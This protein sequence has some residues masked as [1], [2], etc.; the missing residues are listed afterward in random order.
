MQISQVICDTGIVNALIGKQFIYDQ[1]M[2]EVTTSFEFTSN[3]SGQS[4]V[5]MI[6]SQPK[7][8]IGIITSSK[9]YVN[10]L[11]FSFLKEFFSIP[12]N[13][14]TRVGRATDEIITV[15]P[16]L[17]G[18]RTSKLNIYQNILPSDKIIMQGI[19]WLHQLVLGFA[20]E[21]DEYSFTEKIM[22]LCLDICNI[23]L[24]EIGIKR[25][26]PNL[27]G[28]N[29][30]LLLDTISMI[31][32]FFW[33]VRSALS[34]FM[35]ELSKGKDWIKILLEDTLI[36]LSIEPRIRI[37]S[38]ALS[39]SPDNEPN[40][41]D[42]MRPSTTSTY[43]TNSSQYI[44]TIT[45]GK[46]RIEIIALLLLDP[47]SRNSAISMMMNALIACCG[48]D[49]S[50]STTRQSAEP[51][52]ISKQSI[53]SVT[54]STT[55]TATDL[56][57]NSNH[58]LSF[59][60]LAVRIISRTLDIISATRKYP[61]EFDSYNMSI[62]ILHSFTY[63][64]RC[65]QYL[66]IRSE[67]QA[68][69]THS[70]F[71]SQLLFTL[72]QCVRITANDYINICDESIKIE[73][74]KSRCNIL[75]QGITLLTSLT[76]N[77]I[78]MKNELTAI[79]SSSISQ[80][81]NKRIE[82]NNDQLISSNNISNELKNKKLKSIS[83]DNFKLMF[84]QVELY[85]SLETIIILFEMLINSPIM[86]N[87]HVFVN[88]S[89][90][91]LQHGLFD[92]DED[93]PKII[94]SFIISTIFHLLIHCSK[95][96][97]IFILKTFVNLITGRASQVNISICCQT[98]PGVFA[99]ALNLFSYLINEV[100][101]YNIIL[102]TTLGRFSISVSN[103]KQLFH[104]IR[105][106][107]TNNKLNINNSQDNNDY[108]PAYS[109]KVLQALEGMFTIY[110][111]PRHAFVFNGTNSGLLLPSIQTWPIKHGFTFS[112]WFQIESPKLIRR[113]ESNQTDSMHL[114]SSMKHKSTR[115]E[116]RPYLLC[117][118][119]SNNG[120]GIEIYLKT[121]PN[122]LNTFKLIIN[123]YN[124]NNECITL[125]KE[126]KTVAV[127]ESIWHYLAISIQHK[128]IGKPEINILLDDQFYRDKF[129]FNG[130]IKD[131]DTPLIGDCCHSFKTNN[132][133]TTMRGQMGAIYFFNDMLNEG[134]LRS[135]MMLGP[136]YFY[137]FEPQSY[138]PST[139]SPPA[140]SKAMKQSSPTVDPSSILD[141]SLT[142]K[143]LLAYNPAVWLNDHFL[144][145][146]PI[147]NGIIWKISSNSRLA[148]YNVDEIS[149][150]GQIK[151]HAKKLIGTDRSTKQDAYM[152]LDSLGGILILLPIF[153]QFDQSRLLLQPIINTNSNEN[154]NN[155]NNNNNMNSNQSLLLDNQYLIDSTHDDQICSSLLQLLITLIKSRSNN[156]NENN[157]N[158]DSND[159][160]RYLKGIQMIPIFLE[161]ISPKHFNSI[162]VFELLTDLFVL[163]INL[164]EL[165]L[166]DIFL[167]R[168]F[169]H[170]RLWIYTSI[171]I[172]TN[173]IHWLIKFHEINSIRLANVLTV[174]RL[175]T[176]IYLFYD[177]SAENENENTNEQ[178]VQQ[179]DRQTDSQTDK[180]EPYYQ[181]YQSTEQNK[182][183]D[184][185]NQ[186]SMDDDSY[187][188]YI[189]SKY[190]IHSN[191]NT[192]EID[193]N[194]C[195]KN[196]TQIIH[197][198]LFQLL[199]NII[200]IAMII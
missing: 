58:K 94:N 178:T 194:L 38:M 190:W 191:T 175:L 25:I 56:L 22:S 168:I 65:N 152:A 179:T 102:I 169:C 1:N 106:N 163:L 131:I 154:N 69:L 13:S 119:N 59:K 182:L 188:S 149:S 62:L 183:Q 126:L 81:Q 19:R 123:H 64:I 122:N 76:N 164:N 70:D 167:D 34:S 78:R 71:L 186:M 174:K 140:I 54:A 166:Q 177:L 41:Q 195:L 176:S 197:K 43:S 7:D 24:E 26:D 72:S 129:E 128:A 109:C 187:S 45:K 135:M 158:N 125:S 87:Y 117:L 80:T 198:L 181:K 79:L 139:S 121:I 95:K 143:I 14:F 156:N 2:C 116:Y 33:P 112:L 27:L 133:N 92:D 159:N 199:T 108:R 99:L 185:F 148:M 144:D 192:N 55:V 57:D 88:Q 157:N 15:L 47:K 111:G 173:L 8:L 113:R 146:T 161:N 83:F 73:L 189:P 77:N 93:R 101:E 82:N 51:I 40:I 170:F 39:N 155:N 200:I 172:Q 86:S 20:T 49:V 66:T 44:S 61:Y 151:M 37:D 141:G 103:M 68:I 136:S 171:E 85:P 36:T 114:T 63:L 91:L 160:N 107:K 124:E 48:T 30:S 3:V 12:E 180:Y 31:R 23:F 97:Q 60:T 150:G 75:R 134:Q 17:M 100:Q 5:T 50:S 32:P 6:F 16:I 52:R 29:K 110:Y 127:N 96:I 42:L 89:N 162:I 153:K 138:K 84:L 53:T 104:T 4:I 184:Y 118:R 74:M 115:I 132:I 98:S 137:C 105:G 46:Q 196:N 142:S 193:I 145:I 18:L 10:D 120:S 28:P 67:L 35:L 147:Q 9:M 90:D 11:I 21:W 165:L 130:F